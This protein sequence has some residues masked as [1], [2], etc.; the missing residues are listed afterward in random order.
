MI[1]LDEPPRWRIPWLP[2]PQLQRVDMRGKAC[3]VTG[4]SSGIGLQTALRLAEWGA[5]VA[6]VG[7]H[8]KRTPEVCKAIRQYT[9]N[10][11]VSEFI[12]DFASLR[13][14]AEL[15]ERL[16]RRYSQ[17][18]LLVNNA[19]LWLQRREQTLD[20]YERTFAVNH[21]APFLLTTR[22]LE[23]LKAAPRARV[24]NVSSRLN[25]KVKRFKLDDWQVTQRRY[26]GIEVYS[27][28]KLANVLFSNE[29]ARRL[30][31]T[32]VI[33]NSL[34]PGDVATAVT[35]DNGFL[36]WGSNWVG[37]RWLLTP[38][39][40]ARTSLHVATHPRLCD[41]TGRYFSRLRLASPCPLAHDTALARRLWEL[42]EELCE[43]ALTPKN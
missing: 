26:W 38:E 25:A 18:D 17:I 1:A 2:Y 35:R 36:T 31:A 7:R 43:R 42:S 29:L 24:V 39:E 20:G 22:L 12:A 27:Q 40:G 8:P 41:T 32:N 33:S 21:L 11:N 34:H 6:V 23:P 9:S 4:A 37:K 19:G 13:E 30:W 14:V 16:S 15:A 10:P 28:S 3:V 5:E